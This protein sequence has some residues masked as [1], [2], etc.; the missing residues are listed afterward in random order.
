[1]ASFKTYQ[2]TQ[3]KIN[4]ICFSLVVLLCGGSREG[5]GEP[6]PPLILRHFFAKISFEFH[7]LPP[8]P[9]APSKGQVSL[10]CYLII[11]AGIKIKGL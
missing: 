7:P 5:P 1:M 2:Q 3:Y 8:P 4:L 9:L 6:E 10:L 11:C